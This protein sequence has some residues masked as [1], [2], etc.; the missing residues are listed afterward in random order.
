[1]HKSIS[2][3]AFLAISA[4]QLTDAYAWCERYPTVEQEY[5]DSALVFVGTVIEQHDVPEGG[6]DIVATRYLL[7]Q[8]E[9][10][11]GM[12]AK[13]VELLRENTTGR[14]PMVA[15]SSYLVFANLE[16]FESPTDRNLAINS[17]GNSG[18]ESEKATA[19]AAAHQ[20]TAGQGPTSGSTRRGG[21]SG[22]VDTLI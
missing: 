8:K 15:G 13:T 5:K 1:M 21:S 12:Q 17:C 20:L 7:Q 14:F 2:I 16:T 18:I 10:L 11:K 6:Q 3:A 22:L 9:T 4:A 19:V